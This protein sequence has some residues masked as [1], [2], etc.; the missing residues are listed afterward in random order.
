MNLLHAKKASLVH[1]GPSAFL[2]LQ[3]S[4]SKVAPA[5]SSMSLAVAELVS[6]LSEYEWSAHHC[7]REESRNSELVNA[8]REKHL[9]SANINIAQKRREAIY[10]EILSLAHTH[11]HTVTVCGHPRFPL[12]L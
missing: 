6:F 2:L 10:C 5:L 3:D 12:S 1:G 9:V 8:T 11:I 7:L 4:G